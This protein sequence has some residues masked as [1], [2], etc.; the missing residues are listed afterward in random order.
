MALPESAQNM[1][2]REIKAPAGACVFLAEPDEY[3]N[4]PWKGEIRLLY[5]DADGT[6]VPCCVHPRAGVFG[7]LKRQKYSE[8][9]AGTARAEF[10]REMATNRQ[11]MAICN[12][13]EMG[14]VGQEGQSFYNAMNV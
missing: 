14:P 2:Q 10:K 8:I 7:N 5:V 13:C 11:A 3:T 4:H 6:V 9:L 1:T 12:Q